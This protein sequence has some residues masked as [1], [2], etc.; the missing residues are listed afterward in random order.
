MKAFI[1]IAAVILTT[2]SITAQP[3]SNFKKI[4]S[5]FSWMPDG[6]SLILNIMKIDKAEKQPPVPAKYLCDVKTG[7]LNPLPI[8]GSGLI[9]DPNGK[10]IAYIKRINNKPAIYL[11]HLATGI[12]KPLVD[13]TLSKFALTWSPD[14]N[15]IAY[16]IAEGPRDDR[17]TEI[18][19]YN[20]LTKEKKQ[21]TSSGKNK[22]YSPSW[23]PY[24]DQIL[25]YLEKGDGRDQIYLTDKNGSFHQNLSNDTTTLNYYP[26]WINQNTIMYTQDPGKQV[27]LHLDSKKKEIIEAI[28]SSEAKYNA[29]A[30]KI[31][32]VENENR[33]VLY[34][35]KSGARQIVLDLATSK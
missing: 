15:F 26:T 4:I 21:V 9:A 30:N 2:S 11:Y 10:S 29:K 27:I 33:L 35:M 12:E 34:D 14:G 7:K 18:V 17:K 5:S 20:L 13:D 25:Y 31:A 3:D 23:S 19:V 6:Q 16:N 32:Y 1:S 28:N 24:S 22:S 8:N